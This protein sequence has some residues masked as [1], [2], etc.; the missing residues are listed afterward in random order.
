M[1]NFQI[2]GVLII[3]KE[4]AGQVTLQVLLVSENKFAWCENFNILSTKNAVFI[5]H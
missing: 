2:K 4:V 5:I 3:Q 1:L